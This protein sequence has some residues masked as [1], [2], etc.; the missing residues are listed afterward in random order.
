MNLWINTYDE[1]NTLRQ[2]ELLAALDANLANPMINKIFCLMDSRMEGLLTNIPEKVSPIFRN[3][4][5]GNDEWRPRYSDFF[6]EINYRT[7]DNEIN[8]LAN[9]DISFNTSLVHLLRALP[10]GPKICAIISR[11]DDGKH[12]NAGADAW[13]WRGKID[14]AVWGEFF[15]G[16]P[17]CDWRIFQEMKKQ[18]YHIVNPSK[19]VNA[20]HHH[21]SGVRYWTNKDYVEGTPYGPEHG[22]LEPED[23]DSLIRQVNQLT[24]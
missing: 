5:N 20:I 21:T 14:P 3:W 23:F 8:I 2:A 22:H 12:Q 7:L 4:N 10:I 13:A 17:G 24:Q 6:A 19:K 11:L 15:M 1:R 18:G 16:V 9:S